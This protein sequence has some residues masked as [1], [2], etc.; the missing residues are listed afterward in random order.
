MSKNYLL[1]Y[2]EMNKKFTQSFN[3]EIDKISNKYI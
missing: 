1:F 3:K 2:L